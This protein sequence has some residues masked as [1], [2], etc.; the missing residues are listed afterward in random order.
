M[1]EKIGVIGNGSWATALVKMLTDNK[2]EVNWWIRNA[3]SIEYIKRRKHNPNYLS[4]AYF[5]TALLNMDDNAQKIADDSAILLI[6][7]PSAYIVEVLKGLRK[8]SLE[9]KKIISA[10]KGL[11]PGPDVL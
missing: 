1:K 5:D 2:Q 8:G 9:N 10:I 4:F 11:V 3:S 7:V 6:A